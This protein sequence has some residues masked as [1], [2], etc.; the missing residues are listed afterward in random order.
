MLTVQEIQA[1]TFE[2]AMFNGYDPKSVDEVIEQITEDYAAMQ[3]ENAALKA[4]MKVLVDKIDEY[5]SVEDGMR[6][7]LVSAQGIAQETLDKAKLE[8][9]Q[10]IDEAKEKYEVRVKELK[11]EIV[12]E[13]QRLEIAKKNNADFLSKM[14][15]VYEAQKKILVKLAA[16]PELQPAEPTVES[17]AAAM[18]VAEDAAEPAVTENAPQAVEEAAAPA[19]APEQVKVPREVCLKLTY[20]ELQKEKKFT[21]S[22]VNLA[23]SRQHGVNSDTQ[24]LHEQATARFDFGELKFGADYK[25][26]ND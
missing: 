13:E 11:A 17:A 3:K 12:A 7:A 6:R 23:S 1:L 19:A 5:R 25:P 9:Q 26:E 22:E 20:V 21:I 16:A 4:K 14:T 2:K 24:R 8:A 18:P 15:A 10:I